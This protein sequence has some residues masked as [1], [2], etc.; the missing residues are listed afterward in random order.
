M[1]TEPEKE[2]RHE[3]A[4]ELKANTT[5]DCA[6]VLEMEFAEIGTSVVVHDEEGH[7]RAVD[8]VTS[9]G[10][11]AHIDAEEEEIPEAIER[12]WRDPARFERKEVA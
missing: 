7:I 1:K 5:A 2:V 10:I 12:A 3:L 4:E 9:V 11:S 6:E 8:I